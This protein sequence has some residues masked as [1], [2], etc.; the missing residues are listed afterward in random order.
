MSLADQLCAAVIVVFAAPLYNFGVLQHVKTWIDLVVAGAPMSA[1]LREGTPVVVV[2]TR[3]GAYGPGTPREGRDHVIGSVER[4]VSS[5]WGAGLGIVDRGFT[6]VGV[7]PA[8]D[9]FCYLARDMKMAAEEA[10]SVA[11]MS[12]ADRTLA[13]R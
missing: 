7:N 4:I 1:R 12:L 2:V 5:V 3:G 6:L 10:A 13:D 9:E 11:G 8:L